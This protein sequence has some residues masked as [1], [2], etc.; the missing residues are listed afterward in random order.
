M[1]SK[2]SQTTNTSQNQTYTPTGAGYIYGALNN[3]NALAAQ[4]TPTIPTAPVAGLTGQQQ[5]AFNLAGNTGI[6]NPYLQQAS[7][8]FSPSGAQQFYNPMAQSVTNQLQNIFGQQNQQNN[9]SLTQAAGGVGADR[10]AV[11]QGNLANQQTLAAGQTY[12]NLY[13]QAA[14]QAQ[15]AAYGTAGLGA[16]AQ[17]A[18]TSDIQNLLT[19]GG[20]QQQQ[21]QAQLNAPYQQQLAQMALPYQ[22]QQFYSGQVGALAP[23]L[24]GTTWGSGTTTSQYDPSL[25]SQIAGI[26]LLG[27]GILGK[28]SGG[29]VGYDN[30]GGVSPI[31]VS[32]GLFS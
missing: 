14:Q 19:A 28:G 10:I 17:Q 3:A 8:Y 1:G 25:F 13:G 23:A 6:Q 30:G 27:G 15:S 22:L 11:G 20:L 24:G 18:N 32:G 5:Q 21:Q 4:G 9:A 7:N 29:A 31:D 12:A 2:G 26:G 16:Q